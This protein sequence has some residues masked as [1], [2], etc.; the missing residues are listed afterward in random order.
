MT[1]KR[2]TKRA[3]LLSTLSL[4]LCTTMLIGSTFAWFT[5]SVTSSG[6]IITSGT[7]D[8]SME[9]ADGKTDPDNTTWKDASE[10]A[11]F[12]CDNWEP[13][14][15][16][17]RHIKIENKGSLALK[18]QLNI[19]ANGE[20]SD[21]ADVIDVYYADSAVQVTDR[22]ALVDDSKLG[23]LTQALAGVL[24][25]ASG[26]LAPNE[27]HIV[28]IALKMQESAGNEYQNKSIGSD[29]A[30][31]LIATQMT[32]EEDAFDNLYD[33]N[34]IL[35][36][37]AAAAQEALDNAVPGTTIQLIPGV[38]YG[39]LYLR[40]SANNAVTKEVDWV[41]NN[42]RYETYSLYKDITIKGA[43][44]ATVDAIKIEGGVY[45]NTPHSQS[46]TYPIMLSLIELE[47]VVIDG[48]TFTGKGGYDPQG[49]G[50]AINLSER[51]IKVDGLT[52]KNCV[53]KSDDN[54][55]RLLYKTGETNFVQTYTY[56]GETYEFLSDM[57][58][59]TVT[60]C[61][62]DGGYMGLELRETENLTI[63]N[64][65]FNVADRNILLPVNSGCSYSGSITIKGN[66]SNMAKE[67]F[68]RADGTGS[69][70]VVIA[71]N[72]LN[73]YIGADEDYIKVTNANNGCVTI[74]NN[75]MTRAY[76]S[77]TTEDLRD[78]VS[79]AEAGETV[80]LSSGTYT[81][82]SSFA[83][84]VTL[85]CEEGTV[86]EGVSSLNVNGGTVIGATFTATNDNKAVSGTVNGTFK[87]CEFNGVETIRWCYT[88]AGTTVV[89]EDCVVNT[90]MRGIHFDQMDG[91]VIFRN[92]EINGFNAYSGSGTMTFEG[93]TFGHDAS[94]YNGLNIYTDTNLIDC[95]F[96]Y[97]SGNTNFID[98][99]G[100]GKT[101]T[102]TNC[103]A[104]LDGA[105]VA[106]NEFVGG[107]KLSQ[108]TV[109][110]K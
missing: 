77:S 4:L 49:H 16:E 98:M 39:T 8:V 100:T 90:T 85:V 95:T 101:L 80:I 89:F 65:T 12:D 50:N 93:C 48:V 22:A 53:L 43:T 19:V 96:N 59:I 99:E 26:N 37:S 51:N 57:K 62:F 36:N 32:S 66:V 55:A 10:G 24:D 31:H 58:D 38:N 6:N 40:P 108:N 92:C 56:E 46:A 84:G 94:S 69:A 9:W 13:G 72:T 64:N 106:I 18:Y 30:V 78:A 52:L 91:N 60:N 87:D 42:Y 86:F 34:A 33:Q 82:P 44:D 11:I 74:E 88:S 28:T 45:Y 63:T 5:D 2:S 73:N 23:P 67:R 70:T 68:V 3:L 7:L 103:T 81:F 75:T 25:T 27:A 102:I 20:V 54:N 109:V 14:Y 17:V 61:T 47:D 29:F 1:K 105:T 76:V 21:L 83:E 41:G 71:N 104:T 15:V 79:N 110:I 97:E 35:T 107:S